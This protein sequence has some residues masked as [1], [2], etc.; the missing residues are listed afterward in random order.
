MDR[1]R[2]STPVVIP[3]IVVTVALAASTCA[4]GLLIVETCASLE[5]REITFVQEHRVDPLLRPT[6]WLLH[7]GN[8]RTLVALALV[9]IVLALPSRRWRVIVFVVAAVGG[10]WLLASAS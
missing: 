6:R 5:R 1:R 9:G 3:L 4:L 8:I 7:L 10:S 2:A